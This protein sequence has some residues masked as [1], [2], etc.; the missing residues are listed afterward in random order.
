MM[1]YVQR[2]LEEQIIGAR[3]GFPGLVLTGPRCAGK[4]RLLRR[5]FPK[6]SSHLLGDPDIIARLRADP[7]GFLD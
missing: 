5:L 4:T 6:A 2:Q 1:R 7:Q 3:K